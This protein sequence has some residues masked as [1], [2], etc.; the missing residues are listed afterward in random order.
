MAWHSARVVLPKTASRLRE[1]DAGAV[2]VSR[3]LDLPR[4]ESEPG[5]LAETLS[6][7]SKP[8]G[9]WAG[10]G[11]RVRESAAIVP[12]KSLL[13]HGVDRPAWLRPARSCNARPGQRDLRF[14]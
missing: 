5:E 14:R 1:A 3:V 11:A 7:I 9:Q 6:N 4:G 10:G 2:V 8:G 12:R 13:R